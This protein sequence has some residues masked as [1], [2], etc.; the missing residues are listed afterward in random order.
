MQSFFGFLLIVLFS[1]IS[2]SSQAQSPGLVVRPPGGNGTTAL[3]PDGNGYSSLTT[4]GYT[5]DD[6]TE[7]EIPYVVVPVA[8]IEPTG[9]LATGP[10]GGFTD[11][12]KRTDGSGFYLYKDAT[13]LYFR[14]RI[15]GIVNGSKGYS[16]LL[17]TDARIGSSGP[18]ADPNYVAPTG[19][20]PGNPGFEFEVSLQTNFQVAVY[21]IDGSANPGTPTATYP[22]NTHSQIN[23]AYSTDGGNPDYFYDWY[24]PLSALGNPSSVRTAVTTTTSPNSCLQGTRSD[25]YGIDDSNF[26]NTAKAW[27]TVV[28]A[29]PL[30]NLTTFTGVQA[31]CTAAP[32]MNGSISVGSNINVTGTWTRLDATKP[33][34]ATITLY[35]NGVATGST[36][37]STGAT[38]SINVASIATGNVFYAKAVATGESECLTSN[39]VMAVGCTNQTPLTGVTVNCGTRK[40]FQ[41]DNP[42]GVVIRIYTVTSSGYTLFA[43]ETTTAYKVTHP[44][45]T[46]WA[47]EGPN[48][49]NSD[50]CGGGG[51]DVPDAS[52]AITAQLPG[53]C[54]SD[55]LNYCQGL[56]PTTAPVITQTTLYES[57]TTVS[58]TA[59]TGAAVRLFLNGQLFATTTA[60]G[61][62]YTF[63]SLVLRSGDVVNVSAQVSGECVSTR[64]S[65]TVT[66]TTVA[67]TIN[68]DNNGNLI[69]G[70]T[71]ITGKSV[72][73]AGTTIRVY[74]TTPTLLATTTVQASGTWSA[75]VT[76]ATG[77]TYYATA[78]KGSC[79]VSAASANAPA[80]LITTTCPTIT[81]NPSDAS[82]T[83]SGTLP[84]T[85]TGTVR[86]YQDDALIGSQ[87]VTA[88]NVWSIAVSTGT[89]YYNGVLR[90]SAQASGAAE[91]TGCSTYTA[92]CTS[93]LLPSVTPVSTSIVE[94]QTVTYTVS[95]VN[96]QSWYAL[97]D[98]TGTSY[99]TSIYR[100]TSGSFS[101]PSN[102]FNSAGSYSLFISA[103][104]L[105]GCPSNAAPVTVEVAAALLPV[106]FV[107][108]EV[109][110]LGDRAKITWEVADEFNVNHYEVERKV[111]N[112]SF[113][114]IG[115]VD[116]RNGTASGQRYAFTDDGLPQN[117]GT[118]YYRIKE[119]DLDGS[120]FYSDVVSLTNNFDHELTVI[121]NP[122]VSDAI[123]RVTATA[124]EPSEYLV[125]DL[126]GKTVFQGTF[127]LV[128]GINDLQLNELRNLPRGHY[129]LSIGTA[130]RVVYTRMVLQ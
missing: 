66:C 101:L 88:S 45:A 73:A 17:D 32:V 51:N 68:T 12:V 89:I 109:V 95:N 42:T 7:S 11:I 61:G 120:Y 119:M 124:E 2:Y 59:T 115:K 64:T 85:F 54:E 128:K 4:A 1:F 90:A 71:S 43:D 86:L 110:K 10:S 62:N 6:I 118:V 123:I 83:V 97:L 35:K 55:Y 37:V 92:T 117:E 79:T 127:F 116:Y 125:T 24:V 99:A 108:I 57:S 56:T 102:T 9:D 94:G 33:S 78:Q 63:S 30:I 93:P 77:K 106:E 76:V 34:T 100:S 74:D 60:T 98:N 87:N 44:T 3:N 40:G 69:V 58:G 121:P 129:I 114:K 23:V 29:Q 75:S 81:N 50:P 107:R 105:T 18:Y 39:H 122:I 84:S 53:Q 13:N 48:S 5:S 38:W 52:Y 41:G 14:L 82:T 80:L 31:S 22:L 47:Y 103:D 46:T 25:I 26:N 49:Q 36:S 70:A 130:K 65:R 104:K 21:S 16:V 8:I 19:N 91:S 96:A 72:E 67:P 113:Q 126:S 112:G 15:G 28:N 20:K 27:E 111:G